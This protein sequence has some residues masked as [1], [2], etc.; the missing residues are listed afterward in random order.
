MGGTWGRHDEKRLLDA[1]F[2]TRR[3]LANFKTKVEDKATVDV[4]GCVVWHLVHLVG[5]VC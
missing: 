5:E 1:L 3:N 2:L 4:Y